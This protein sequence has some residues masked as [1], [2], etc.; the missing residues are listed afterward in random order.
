MR[1]RATPK[2]G[3]SLLERYPD[4][5]AEWHKEYNREIALSPDITSYLSNVI[6]TWE[7]PNG[8]IWKARV[9]KRV[10][11][12]YAQCRS[13]ESNVSEIEE[14]LRI[15]VASNP[16]FEEVSENEAKFTLNGFETLVD[17]R[18]VNRGRNFVVEYDG[19][20]WHKGAK[21]T[22]RDINKTLFLINEGYDVIRI[23]EN[24]LPH[25]NLEN[26]RFRQITY[27]HSLEYDKVSELVEN[28]KTKLDEIYDNCGTSDNVFEEILPI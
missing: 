2:A 7:C 19:S 10:N 18:G 17:I 22:A 9:S 25:L 14:L 16:N 3:D 20:R 6:V 28:I 4:I 26:D 27:R 11:K 23:R 24:N 8:H 15:A 1:F 21:R 5:A 12:G 13:C